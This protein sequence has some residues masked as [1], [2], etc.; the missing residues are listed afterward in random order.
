MSDYWAS[1]PMLG[2]EMVLETIN[3]D[4]EKEKGAQDEKYHL[5]QN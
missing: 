2:N 1:Y 5:M 4:Q 3:R